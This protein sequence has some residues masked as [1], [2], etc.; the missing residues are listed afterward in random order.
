MA[1]KY[2]IPSEEVQHIIDLQDEETA[3]KLCTDY[4]LAISPQD[5]MIEFRNTSIKH[6]AKTPLMPGKN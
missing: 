6:L 4:N 5:F 2:N 3:K 1:K